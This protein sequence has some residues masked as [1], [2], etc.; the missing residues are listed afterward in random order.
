MGRPLK[1]YVDWFPHD[2]NASRQS[3]TIEALEMATGANGEKLGNDGYAFWFKLLEILASTDGMFM[4]CS[5]PD[6]WLRLISRTRISDQ[7]AHIC[8]NTLV[9]MGAIDKD[10]WEKQQIIWCPN[11]VSRVQNALPRRGLDLLPPLSERA[12]E[13]TSS[14]VRR[15]VSVEDTAFGPVEIDHDWAR[16]EE[17]YAQQIGE[18]PMGRHLDAL[19]DLYEEMGADIVI[20]AIEYTNDEQPDNMRTYLTGVLRKWKK[21]GVRTVA[22]AQ[23]QITEFKR[24]SSRH[25]DQYDAPPPP[26]DDGEPV[27]W[28]D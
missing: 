28:V 10:R 8:L 15:N 16:V 17:S 25:Q 19:R 4:D 12:P 14:D 27:R 18:L 5:K 1:R 2:A 13:N 9:T 11:L 20:L 7:D 23:A 22:Q 24:R 26:H 3:N 6:Q 21:A